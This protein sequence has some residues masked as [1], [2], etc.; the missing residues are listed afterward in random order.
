LRLLRSLHPSV[1]FDGHTVSVEKYYD[2]DA[3]LGGRGL[4]L[5]PCVFAWSDVIVLTAE[6]YSPTMS[7]S[8]RGLSALWER[9]L[10][11]RRAALGE[12]IGRTRAALLAQLDLPMSTTQ[13]AAALELTAPTLNVHLH[14]LRGAGIVSSRRDGRAVLYARTR[15]GEHLLAGAEEATA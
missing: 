11:P 9:H 6:P 14:A 5:V 4:R 7:Y 1:G 12:V 3:T 15:L 10:T 13:I 2:G 8:P